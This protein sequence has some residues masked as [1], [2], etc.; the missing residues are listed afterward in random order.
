MG[1]DAGPESCK[2]FAKTILASKTI[3]WNGPAGVFEFDSFANGSK[4]TLDAC[5]E[6]KQ[7]GA[8]V[9]VGGGD[10]A[11]L[12]AKYGAEDKLSH[13]ST[14]GGAL[15]SG[16]LLA[17]ATGADG[18]CLSFAGASLELLEGKVSCSSRC[19]TSTTRADSL[20]PSFRNFPESRRLARRSELSAQSRQGRRVTL[21]LVGDRKSVGCSWTRQTDMEIS[22]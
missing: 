10:T 8:D 4:A 6:S 18:A 16:G 11:T 20:S 12:A 13:V 5:I 2:L 7:N 3:L 22:G 14:G 19:S 21:R 1:L 17:K 9:V 15:H